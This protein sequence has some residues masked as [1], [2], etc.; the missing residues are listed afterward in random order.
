MIYLVIGN[1]CLCRPRVADRATV[2]I[3]PWRS[4]ARRLQPFSRT[5]PRSTSTR[6]VNAANEGLRPGGGVCGAI[7]RGAGP[8]LA[9][10]C[11][12]VAP[13]PT[14]EARI[15][16]GFALPAK[17]VIH[18]VGPIWRGGHRGEPDLLASAYRASLALARK[19]QLA[20]IAFPAI[21]TGIYGTR[22]RRPRTSRPRASSTRCRTPARSHTS[23]SPVSACRSWTPI[24]PPASLGDAAAASSLS[25]S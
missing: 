8:E 19:Y 25:A 6:S 3:T 7:H 16:P 17:Y 15:T 14:G 24:A 4:R 18:A 20:S 13:C 21:S 23:C 22:F 12:K 1:R 2:P 10:A 9:R 5:S 11:A